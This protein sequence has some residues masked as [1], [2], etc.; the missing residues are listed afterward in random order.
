MIRNVYMSLNCFTIKSGR[1]NTKSKHKIYSVRMG[2]VNV[3]G[4][5]HKEIYNSMGSNLV[6]FF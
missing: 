1:V 6:L 2:T 4:E 3:I 5:G